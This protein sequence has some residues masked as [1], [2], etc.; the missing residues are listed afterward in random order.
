MASIASSLVGLAGACSTVYM[1]LPL[2]AKVDIVSQAR[3]LAVSEAI[4]ALALLLATALAKS[5]DTGEAP[6][7]DADHTGSALCEAGVFV[8][9]FA[10]VCCWLWMLLIAVGASTVRRET[11]HFVYKY[12]CCVWPTALVFA[13]P[14]AIP[15]W[16]GSNL[17]CTYILGQVPLGFYTALLLAVCVLTVGATARLLLLHLPRLAPYLPPPRT[18]QLRGACW[19]VGS[20]SVLWLPFLTYS[21]AV[22]FGASRPPWADAYERVALPL[23][24]GLVAAVCWCSGMLSQELSP[25]AMPLNAKFTYSGATAGGRVL[26]GDGHFGF[27]GSGTD[28]LGD[29]ISDELCLGDVL[30]FSDGALAD[31]DCAGEADAGRQGQGSGVGLLE[32]ALDPSQDGSVLDSTVDLDST[33]GSEMDGERELASPDLGSRARDYARAHS[34]DGDTERIN[35][36]GGR[37]DDAA[38]GDKESHVGGGGDGRGQST[39]P[40]T[41]GGSR[42]KSRQRDRNAHGIGFQGGRRQ[43]AVLTVERR[44]AY[45]AQLTAEQREGL[46]D[47]I[48]NARRIEAERWYQRQMQRRKLPKPLNVANI[49]HGAAADEPVSSATSAAAGL[50]TSGAL[51]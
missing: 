44:L 35:A 19:L 49:N 6:A 22:V 10:F 12:Q 4:L 28:G 9:Y 21:A 36:P 41:L 46:L 20:A 37:A 47:D 11:Q 51:S 33:V 32:S 23:Q 34:A 24:G 7:A 29:G 42:S 17:S 14:A 13:T 26:G 8:Q 40:G 38:G 25:A 43:E 50:S 27:G 48:S 5:S 45:D 31:A 15:A 1:S 16:N 2:R 39:G 18:Q 3:S 30:L